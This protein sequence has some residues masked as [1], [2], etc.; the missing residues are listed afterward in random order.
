MAMGLGWGGWVDVERGGGDLCKGGCL[1][2][3]F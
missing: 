2:F 1:E 3:G